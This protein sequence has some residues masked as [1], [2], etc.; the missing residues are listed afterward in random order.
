VDGAKSVVF[1]LAE[2]REGEG[3]IDRDGCDFT[4]GI[5]GGCAPSEARHLRVEWLRIDTLS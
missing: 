2:G 1:S 4:D 5:V 3:E